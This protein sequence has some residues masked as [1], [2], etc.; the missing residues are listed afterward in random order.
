MLVSEMIETWRGAGQVFNGDVRTLNSTA[1]VMMIKFRGTTELGVIAQ[2]WVLTHLQP[3]NMVNGTYKR[4][5]P[6]A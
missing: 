2:L 3:P 6:I 1:Y 4:L 5:T